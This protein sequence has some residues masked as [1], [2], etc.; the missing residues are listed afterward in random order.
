[1]EPVHIRP[2]LPEDWEAVKN[3][4][5]SGIATGNAT[6]ETSAPSWQNWHGNHLAV[7]RLLA[8]AEGEVAGWAALSSVSGRCVYG[9]VAEVSVYV[10]P[11]H[12]GK[13]VG[14]LLLESLIAESEEKGI[15]TLQAGIFSENEASVRL[16]EKAGFRIVGYRERIGQLHGV[17]KDTLLLERRSK[18]VGVE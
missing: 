13:G 5:E 8:D 15:W 7:G 10:S 16:H 4:Y 9:G 3:I 1:M 12:K 11:N 6:F 14:S 17:W 18:K 2:L